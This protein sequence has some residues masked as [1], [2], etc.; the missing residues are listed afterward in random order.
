MP[1]ALV[2]ATAKEMR[3]ALGFLREPPEVESG[4]EKLFVLAGREIVPCVTGLGVVNAALALGRILSLPG[5]EG[6]ANLGV[7]GAF[8]LRALPLGTVCVVRQEIWPEYG[9]LGPHG[10]DPRA[11]GF[12]LG[13]A[14]GTTVWDRLDLHPRQAAARLDL[15]LSGLWPEAVSLTVSGVTG[16]PERAVELERSFR[17]DVE[18]MEGFALAYGCARVGVP[19]VEVRAVSNRVGSRPPVD[20]DLDLALSRLGAACAALF[21]NR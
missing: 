18:N 15:G 9:L 20:W 14:D 1:I 5:I 3:G 17:A 12:A 11:L 10:V 4:R 13:E 21:M 7:A 2:A 16:T 8:D 19:F 6:V